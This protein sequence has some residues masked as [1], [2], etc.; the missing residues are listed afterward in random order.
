MISI[1]TTT[2]NYSEYINEA[3]SSILKQTYKDFEYII[4]DDGSTDQTEYVVLNFN[5]PRIRYI[6]INHQGRSAALN[7]ALKQARYEIIALMDADDISHPQRIEKEIEKLKNE[8]QIV[9]CDAAY[10]I[11]NKITYINRSPKNYLELKS[12]ILLHGHLNNSS[13][14][15]YKR[16]I[17]ENFGYDESLIAYEDYD[18]WMRLFVKSEFIVLKTPFHFVRLHNQSLTTSNQSKLKSVLYSIQEKYFN[19]VNALLEISDKDVIK[20][21]A[22]REYFYGNKDKSREYWKSLSFNDFDIKIVL[23]FM[24]SYLSDNFLSA[25]KNSRLRLRI[26]FIFR[27]G[28]E[29]E[30]IQHDFEAILRTLI[31]N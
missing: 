30:N 23:A 22:W 26:E 2:Y 29:S 21:K 25:L 15:F 4:V 13:A 16:Y 10:F 24:F 6:K 5:D 19:Q 7:F 8:N 1:V 3:V 28:K 27:K 11:N 14:L 31:N 9:F 18:L 20:L 17:M 12:K